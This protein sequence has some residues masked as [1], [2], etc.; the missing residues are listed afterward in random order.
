[1][2]IGKFVLRTGSPSAEQFAA[3]H[4]A[5][6]AQATDGI[7]S[8]VSLLGSNFV[9]VIAN[10]AALAKGLWNNS[11]PPSVP[12]PTEFLATARQRCFGQR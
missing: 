9:G 2:K 7:V 11:A 6:I 12:T 5:S 3:G 8:G 10:D 1:M 4:L